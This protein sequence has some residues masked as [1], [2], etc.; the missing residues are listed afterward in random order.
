[1]AKQLDARKSGKG[2]GVQVATTWYWYENWYDQVIEKLAN[3]W[4][5]PNSSFGRSR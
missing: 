1:L 3:G 2:Y 5:R 4:G